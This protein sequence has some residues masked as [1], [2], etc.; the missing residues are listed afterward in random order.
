MN[1]FADDINSPKQTAGPTLVV[2][3]I[4]NWKKR[5]RMI[6]YLEGFQFTGIDSIRASYVREV[7]PDMILSTLVGRDHDAIDL[8]RK[9]A[10]MEYQGSYRVLV[11]DIPNADLILD[12]VRNVAPELDF[13]VIDLAEILQ[14]S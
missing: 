6:P 3:D 4:E 7:D 12:E 1:R 9:L 11:N 8:A 13:D 2:G 5:G 14:L 10:F